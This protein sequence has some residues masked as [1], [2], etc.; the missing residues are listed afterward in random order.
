MYIKSRIISLVLDHNF[1]ITK[2]ENFKK[3]HIIKN[4]KS[5]NILKVRNKLFE[6]Y[7]IKEKED[8]LL[9]DNF[10]DFATNYKD[11]INVDKIISYYRSLGEKNKKKFD[12]NSK[13]IEEKRK[14]LDELDL[15]LNA[16]IIENIKID[17]EEIE[18][19]YE[20][21]IN[22]KKQEINLKK[23]ELEMYHQIFNFLI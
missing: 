19:L 15:Q 6:K 7:K 10:I 1:F 9:K 20:K 17:K 14:Y 8:E 12:E 13:I 22:E 4:S 23:H 11:Y 18:K 3:P 16:V 5:T 2:L 21:K